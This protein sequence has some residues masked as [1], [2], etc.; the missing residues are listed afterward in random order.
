VVEKWFEP[1]YKL[2]GKPTAGAAQAVGASVE[3]VN[4]PG[5]PGPRGHRSHGADGAVPPAGRDAA[6][7]SPGAL[8]RQHR[9]RVSPPAVGVP[10]AET[11]DDLEAVGIYIGRDFADLRRRLPEGLQ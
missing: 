5:Q 2:Q 4:E 10:V 7:E 6:D 3:P 8:H 1:L 9:I 11:V